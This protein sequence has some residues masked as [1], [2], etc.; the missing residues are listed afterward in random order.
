MPTIEIL[1]LHDNNLK[2]N[3]FNWLRELC[4]GGQV[5]EYTIPGNHISCTKN[6]NNDVKQEN[7]DATHSTTPLLPM[8]VREQGE[9]A[10]VKIYL[11]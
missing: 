4:E 9:P 7:R 1:T 6:D 10:F 2:G 5:Q 3:D 11:Y 8:Q